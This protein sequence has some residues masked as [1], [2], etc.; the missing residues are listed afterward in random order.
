MIFILSSMPGD[1]FPEVDIRFSDKYVHLIVYGILFTL[2]FYSLKNQCKYA[3]LKKFASEYSVLFTAL[4]G[5]TDEIH[6]YF[7]PKRS[8]DIYDWIAD[9]TGALLIYT[10]IRIYNYKHKAVTAFFLLIIITECSCTSSLQKNNNYTI[11]V[12]EEEAWLNL[13]PVIDERQNN[14][15]FNIG[16]KME[17]F[18]DIKNLSVKDLIIY[19]NN[20]T[21]K[22]NNFETEI[23]KAGRNVKIKIFQLADEK[24]LDRNKPYPDEAQFSFRIYKNDDQIKR[25]KTSQLNINKVY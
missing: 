10:I 21:L 24:Y 2:F 22:N 14:F 13:M 7:V 25:I 23:T 4:Y 1:K 8:C 11:S 15:G 19:L 3:K 18:P 12:T 9:V 6:Q 17:N 5:M 16:V 20:D